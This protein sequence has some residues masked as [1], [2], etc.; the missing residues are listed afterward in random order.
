[1]LD[2]HPNFRKER[3]C[4]KTTPLSCHLA[5]VNDTTTCFFRL[6]VFLTDIPRNHV[7]L[8]TGID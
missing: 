4:P 3:P 6:T 8:N 2:D 7:R 5:S 1:M